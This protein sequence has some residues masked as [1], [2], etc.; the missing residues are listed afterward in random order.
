MICKLTCLLAACTIIVAPCLA[1]TF[2]VKGSVHCH[3]NA[4][5]GDSPPQVVAD[6]Y[7][8]HGYGFLV[9]TDHN[10]LTDPAAIT[11][12]D[13][14]VLIPGEEISAGFE[15]APIHV[16]AL[17]ISKQLPVATGKSKI[18]VLQR[19]IDLIADDG[20]LALIDHP[21][22]HYAFGAREMSAVSRWVLFEVCNASSGCNN[23]GD[24]T[25]PSTEAMW[26][27]MLTAGLTCYGVASDDAHHYAKFGPQYDNPG[28]GWIVVRVGKLTAQDILA[29][30]AA[31]DFYASTGVELEDVRFADGVLKVSV[32]PVEGKTYRI[33]FI[34][35]GGTIIKEEGGASASCA[36]GGDP[37]A[38]L[39][40]KVIASDGT[41]ALTQPA[42]KMTNTP[43]FRAWVADAFVKVLPGAAKPAKTPNV[44]AIDAVCNEYESGQ[45]VVTAAGKID[46][47]TAKC[48]P[49]TGPAGPKPQIK[50]NFVGCVPVRRNTPDTPPEH[51][52]GPPGDFPDP[53]LEDRWVPVEAGKNQP[54]WVTVYVPKG[55]APGEYD[56]SVEITGD[57]AGVS[58]PI[59]ITVHPFTLPDARTL[60][61]TNWFSPG[62]LAKAHGCEPYTEPFWKWLE[63]WA[64]FMADHRQDTVITPIINLI[65]AQD[66]G[67]GNLTFD[68]SQF[69]RWVELFK[70]A[71]V[72][73]T[74]EGG[75][76]AGRTGGVWEAKDFDGYYPVITMPDGSR[77]QNPA[78]TVT[79]EEYKQ[80]LA[81]FLPALVKHLEAKGWLDSYVQHLTDEPI[82]ENAESYK[83]AASYIREFAPKLRIIDA[84][85]CDQIA[86]AIDIWVP[87]PSEFGP[88]MDFFKAR[89][90]AGEEVWIYTC[91]SPRGKYMNRFIDYPLLDVRLL[92]WVNFKYDLPGYLHWGFNYWH[93]DPFADLE[94]H[95]GGDN[96]LPAGDSHIAY[97]GKTGP[98]SSIRLE[99]MRDGIEDYELLRLLE[100]RNPKLAR[101]ICDSIVQSLTE[102]SLDPVEFRKAR[103]RLI[104]ALAQ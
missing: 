67:K 40:A 48:G 7:R 71:G 70:R 63:V 61:I 87:Q 42:R 91:L 30:I 28:K 80:F 11:P 45:I 43:R 57:G 52:V 93:G 1:N 46:R 88:K 29:A 77:R 98:L 38:Y 79:S 13:G 18:D 92:H 59:K 8:T 16:N 25:H 64:R 53:L 31:G 54:I 23:E 103:G 58:V 12:A 9:I 66:D 47:L 10:K 6:W 84:S 21:N 19:N 37:Y 39:R 72:I 27:E 97:P 90:K 62:N 95:W 17:G 2:W 83:K 74:I 26:D 44:V 99:A 49:V 82:P 96:Y 100:A 32:K 22:W 78:V 14:F 85:M 41:I 51:I 50:L 101:E 15:G 89:Q 73:G 104:S 24:A 102:Y 4:S 86:G 68:F 81:Q 76:L 33:Q 94:P 5:D 55:A 60:H 56:T 69:D 20:G 65:T 36:I 34:G 35:P 3:T 75:H